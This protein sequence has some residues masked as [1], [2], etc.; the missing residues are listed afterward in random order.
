MAC[1]RGG[2]PACSFATITHES[3]RTPSIRHS[4]TLS[5]V[6]SRNGHRFYWLV[7]ATTRQSSAS[8]SAVGPM[9]KRSQRLDEAKFPNA[10]SAMAPT[11][12]HAPQR[13][14]PDGIADPQY[15]ARPRTRR[16]PR[17][18]VTAPT[19]LAIRRRVGRTSCAPPHAP[20]PQ[21]AP[22]ARAIWNPAT[23]TNPAAAA[24]AARR[25]TK[26]AV[27]ETSILPSLRDSSEQA[28]PSV[29]SQI[30]SPGRCAGELSSQ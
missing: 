26:G 1:R 8:R 22:K 27:V 23:R 12:A 17:M 16:A 9:N 11:S 6:N 7:S 29:R 28:M 21:G 3:R 2:V 5:H 10:L 15:P 30:D 25:A 4:N 14:T 24:I 20:R 18:S 13:K 19:E